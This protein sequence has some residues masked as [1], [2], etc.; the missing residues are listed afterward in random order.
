MEQN[1]R[2]LPLLLILM[3]AFMVPLILSR[4]RRL[5]VVVGEILAGILIGKSGLRLIREDF[6]LAFLAGVV[7]SFLT[8]AEDEQIRHK[9]DAIGFGFFV[10]I[11]FITVGMRFDFPALLRNKATW[12]LTPLLLAAA[13]VIKI[14]PALLFRIFF[15]WRKTL[16]GGLILSARLSLII[17]ASGIGLRLGVIGEATNA[18]FI[19]VAAV[20]STL[21]PIL[22]NWIIPLKEQKQTLPILIYGLN[23]LARQVARELERRGE[24]VNFIQLPAFPDS[25][26][27]GTGLPAAEDEKKVTSFEKQILQNARALLALDTDDGNNLWVCRKAIKSGLAHVIAMVHNPTQLPAFN[28]LGGSADIYAG[29]VQGHSARPDGLQS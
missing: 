27:D 12:I 18:A 28:E 13:F 17:A 29:H 11:F 10:P 15:P 23:D 22:F 9:L 7:F 26:K 4:M 5:P 8:P 6:T 20:T 21:A 16:G 25:S 24:K 3:L 2:F 19:L 1:L 14:F